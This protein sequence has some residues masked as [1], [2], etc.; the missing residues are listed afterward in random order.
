MAPECEATVD[1]VSRLLN[2]LSW[3]HHL[4]TMHYLGQAFDPEHMHSISIIAVDALN[5]KSHLPDYEEAVQRAG[6]AALVEVARLQP[7]IDDGGS[8]E[9]A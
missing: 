1:H 6:R 9:D 3:I 5:G 2:A 7:F 8:E 4:A